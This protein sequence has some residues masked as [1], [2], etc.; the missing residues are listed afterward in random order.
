[1]LKLAHSNQYNPILTNYMSKDPVFKQDHPHR[2]LGLGLP[3]FGER[4]SVQ[5]HACAPSSG[6]GE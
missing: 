4:G 3:S 6:V 5:I 2:N 1:M